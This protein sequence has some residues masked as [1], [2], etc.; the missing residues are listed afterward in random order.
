ML[1]IKWWEW[2]DEKIKANI[3]LMYD[4]ENFTSKFYK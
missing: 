3:G 4:I 2:D 1:Y